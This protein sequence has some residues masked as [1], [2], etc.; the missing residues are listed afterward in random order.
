MKLKCTYFVLFIWLT[1]SITACSTNN[2]LV[3]ASSDANHGLINELN[4]A[5]GSSGMEQIGDRSY[6]VVYDLKRN[7]DGIR[8][9]LV[10]VSHSVLSVSP[11][12][13]T[14]WGKGGIAN[15]LESICAVTG[16]PNEYL[17]AESGDWQ[18]QLGRIFHIR[19][20]TT[21]LKATVIGSVE[22]PMIHRNDIDEI[23]DQYEA[24]ACLPYDENH[25]IVVLG[26]RGGSTVYPNG[27]V[28]WGIL[29]ID[30]HTF[31]MGEKGLAGIDVN[32]PGNWTHRETKRNIT[33]FHIDPKGGIWASASEDP[34]DIG[35]FYSVLYLLGH[36]EPANKEIPFAI[37]KTIGV[38]KTINGFKVEALSGQCK[39]I[40]GSHSFGTED[41]LFGGVWRP[42]DIESN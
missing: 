10:N 41:E 18:G 8:L 2:A 21:K 22:I 5:G 37:Y 9:G 3:L 38:S 17:I 42:I 36:T 39:G 14:S 6:L 30:D 33:D 16:K 29:N 11:I 13:F 12:P 19:V 7:N 40:S 28:R 32:V 25:R 15:D 34:G 20:D 31:H 35:P 24:M 4:T 23:G 26:E 27:K 1:V